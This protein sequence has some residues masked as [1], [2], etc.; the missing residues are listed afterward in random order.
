MINIIKQ[1]MIVVIVFVS[2]SYA[3]EP[4]TGFDGLTMTSSLDELKAKGFELV[5]LL[6][7][8]D[9][10]RSVYKPTPK[11]FIFDDSK[12][13][14]VTQSCYLNDTMMLKVCR[15]GSIE[16]GIADNLY[17]SDEYFLRDPSAPKIYADTIFDM[18]Y[19]K[20]SILR[21]TGGKGGIIRAGGF[22]GTPL[23][24]EDYLVLRRESK[25]E[26]FDSTTIEYA[27][28]FRS[29]N[30][31][32]WKRNMNWDSQAISEILDKKY[33]TPVIK[34]VDSDLT[35]YVYG[36]NTGEN[37]I[38]LYVKSTSKPY[39]PGFDFEIIGMTYYNFPFVNSMK[40]SAENFITKEQVAFAQ[41]LMN[42]RDQIVKSRDC[43]F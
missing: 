33:G 24:T 13:D 11:K 29:G 30:V 17:N 21:P 9:A 25:Q 35:A 10:Y 8:K 23:F 4:V 16:K 12:F 40:K 41:D 20:V 1:L 15:Y 3:V 38:R 37:R 14:T 32:F 6:N 28:L 2:I 31:M 7:G 22:F 5:P 18:L 27:M 42:V 19:K 43:S 34:D 26:G 36:V 39:G